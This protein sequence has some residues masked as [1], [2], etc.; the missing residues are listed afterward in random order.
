MDFLEELEERVLC[1][2][3]AMGSMLLA[4][5]IPLERCF[6]ELCVS[7]PDRI[8]SIHEDYVGAGARVIET[9]T[10][11]AN[12]VRLERFGLEGRVSEINRAGVELAKRAAP[13]RNVYIAGSVGPLGISADG[14]TARGI[15][16]T[17]CFHDQ[18]TALLEAEVDVI[19]FETFMDIDEMEIAFRAKKALSNIPDVCSFACAPDAKLVSGLSLVD[20]FNKMRE[21]GA[22][23]V[24]VNCLNDPDAMLHALKSLPAG[25]RIAVY[26][27]AGQ[28]QFRGG[29]YVYPTAPDAFARRAREMVAAGAQLIGGCCGTTP[30][31]IAALSAMIAKL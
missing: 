2:D 18:V 9:N 27:S 17:Q 20:A 25:G 5:G 8:Q 7:E 11:G 26:P 29:T 14:A 24:G 22:N 19:F 13:G 16:R 30:D 3:G 1:G 12:A 6:E 31:H 10:F 28:P 4:A 15:D 21:L 23:V